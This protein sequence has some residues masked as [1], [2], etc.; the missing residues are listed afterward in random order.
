MWRIRVDSTIY[1][2][3][4]EIELDKQKKH[5]IEVVVDRLVIRK[6]QK[7][8]GA[9]TE[10]QR[11]QLQLVQS[12]QLSMMS[13]QREKII[14]MKMASKSRR[15]SQCYTMILNHHFGNESRIH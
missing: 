3:S 5:T 9:T 2:L 10:A 1:D 14:L 8:D 6:S 11:T 4:D 12:D 15:L 13:T 7:V